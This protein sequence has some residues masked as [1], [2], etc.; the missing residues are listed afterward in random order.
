M[1]ESWKRVVL[2]ISGE[3]LGGGRGISPEVFSKIAGEIKEVYELKVRMGVVVGGGNIFRGAHAEKIGM[4]RAIA[5]HVG[6]LATVINSLI[7]Q[8]YL[9]KLGVPSRVLSAIEVKGPCEPYIRGR[10]IRHLE[11]GR[12]LILGGG[13]GNPYFSTDTAASLR[14]SELGAEAILK[15]TK[16]EG[17]YDADPFRKRSAKMFDRISYI[18]VINKGLKVMDHTAVTMC[19][20]KSIPIVVFNIMRPG[21][22]KK[23]IVGEKV[24]TTIGG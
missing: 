4:D 20:E 17:V 1:G 12:I 2:K 11:K 21:N 5:D 22:L 13:T 10:A 23:I 14:A 18:E 9:E 24:G 16:V 15:A 6:M 8:N 7:L 3:V 19:M